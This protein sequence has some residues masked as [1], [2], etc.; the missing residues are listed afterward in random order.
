MAETCNTVPKCNECKMKSGTW[1]DTVKSIFE[2]FAIVILD[3]G[4]VIKIPT[5]RIVCDINV[6]V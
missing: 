4:E 3:N 2:T 1:I 6:T 5:D